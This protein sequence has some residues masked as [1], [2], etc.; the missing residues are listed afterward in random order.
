MT[1]VAVDI[2]DLETLVMTTG[3][4]T[5]I[6]GALAAR[7]MDPFVRTHLNFTAA[8]ERLAA[9]MRNVRRAEA[10]TLVAWDGALEEDEIEFLRSLDGKQ[11]D[12]GAAPLVLS[13]SDKAPVAGVSMSVADKLAAKGC[14]VIGQIVR[15]VLW[16]GD[17]QPELT[18]DPTGFPV[19]IT[20]RG[21]Q[22]LAKIEAEKK[23]LVNG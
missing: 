17:K 14:V 3:A 16:A 9:A 5:T 15:G 4:L 19:K 8:H 13:R 22:K 10:G 1:T 11:A 12:K 6:E 21:R 2:D 18:V 20:D 7:K 23:A